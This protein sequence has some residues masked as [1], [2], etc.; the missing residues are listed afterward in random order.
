MNIYDVASWILTME[1]VP[2]ATAEEI[3]ANPADAVQANAEQAASLIDAFSGSEWWSWG[4]AGTM[5]ALAVA[6]KVA[7][8]LWGFGAD[9]LYK[10]VAPYAK[11][12]EQ[13]K[14]NMMASTAKCL[15]ETI[16]SM[17]NHGSIGEL[18]DKLRQNIPEDVEIAIHEVAG[19][20]KAKE[21]TDAG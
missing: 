14:A 9:L 13:E 8:G 3:A 6:R 19:A 11:R 4:I 7:P 12:R 20:Y 1:A 18:K 15:I 10:L 5:V 21:N 17:P 2:A 16:E